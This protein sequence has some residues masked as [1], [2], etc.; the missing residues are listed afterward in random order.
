M[1]GGMHGRP[2]AGEYAGGSVSSAGDVNG[3]GLANLIVGSCYDGSN[4]ASRG[5]AYVVFGKKD[6]GAIDLNAVAAGASG[7]KISGQSR[8]DYA[9]RSVSSAGD[10]NGDGFTDLIVG[11]IYNDANGQDSDAVYVIYGSSH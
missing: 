6:G 2:S 10:F 4:G 11:A 7:F 9:G 5:A 1:A 3:D 8:F